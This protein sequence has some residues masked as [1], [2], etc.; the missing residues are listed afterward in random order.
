LTELEVRATLKDYF[1]SEGFTVRLGSR[2]PDLVCFHPTWK[3]LW[4]IEAKGWTDNS[5]DRRDRFEIG[6]GQICQ[7]DAANCKS[8]AGFGVLLPDEAVTYGLA[9]LEGDK[10][11]EFNYHSLCQ[12]VRKEV[13]RALTLYFFFVKS[14][15]LA[16]TIIAPHDLTF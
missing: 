6:L 1:E 14:D 12:S 10:L 2:G 5:T 16:P 11:V 15:A 4:I 8:L 3:R 13:R 9:F 7:R